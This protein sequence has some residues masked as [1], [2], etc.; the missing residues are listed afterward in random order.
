MREPLTDLSMLQDQL[1]Q[2]THEK[3]QL[4]LYRQ[5]YLL[6]QRNFKLMLTFEEPQQVLQQLHN[7]L[8]SLMTFDQAMV[9]RASP[10]SADGQM[11]A[12]WPVT[13]PPLHWPADALQRLTQQV[14]HL[15]DIAQCP[16]W[17]ATLAQQFSQS[18]CALSIPI[19]V[20]RQ[21]Y[22]LLLLSQQIGAFSSANREQAEI[23][24]SLASNTL[25]QLDNRRLSQQQDALVAQ[26]QRLEQSMMRQEKMA[27]IGLLT[28]GVAHELNN[29]L[30]YIYSNLQTMQHYLQQFSQFYLQVQ[31]QAAVGTTT[32]L[33]AML[34]DAADL[35]DESL[36]G[37]RRAR[38]IISQ[39][40]QFSHP[41]DSATGT[42]DLAAVLESTLNIANSQIK[43]RAK[44]AIEITQRP[45]PVHGN[46]TRLSQLILNLVLNACQ[47]VSVQDGLI[48][49]RLTLA[50]AW[51]HL[52]VTDNGHGIKPQHQ[53]H[54]FTPFFTTKPVGEGTGLGLSI[55]R[56]IAEQH[57]GTLTLEHSSTAGSTFL[58]MLP[59]QPV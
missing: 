12:C 59:E 55:G 28:A 5:L 4:E 2:L 19:P 50:Q 7:D 22:V 58:L 57:G 35:L 9:I 24:A 31:P 16:W 44:L 45:A 34:T 29:P 21:V 53:P 8:Q 37:A 32:Q 33:S 1:A 17:P 43:H 39:L 36:D 40:R 54:I 15:Y 13:A 25:S 48:Q 46:A 47:A 51:W 27:A 49:I 10:E 38:Q 6:Q 30:G 52:T 3:H 56:A 26:Q 41:D 11:V 20:G 14:Q 23:L 42:L 18:R